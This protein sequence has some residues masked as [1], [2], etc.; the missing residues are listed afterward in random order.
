MRRRGWLFKPDTDVFPRPE[1]SMEPSNLA[2]DLMLVSRQRSYPKFNLLDP[3]VAIPGIGRRKGGDLALHVSYGA[4][5]LLEEVVERF[6]VLLDFWKTVNIRAMDRKAKGL[7][8]L[9]D[10]C[11]ELGYRSLSCDVE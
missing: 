6:A 10:F 1:P 2:D 8:I 11:V 3:F 4:D 5:H 7:E 9:T